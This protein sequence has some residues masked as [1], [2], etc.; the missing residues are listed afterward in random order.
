VATTKPK[1][2][3]LSVIRSTSNFWG[4]FVSKLN[5]KLGKIEEKA[6]AVFGQC[7]KKLTERAN[8]PPSKQNRAKL[9]H[10]STSI[11]VFKRKW[12]CSIL[13]PVL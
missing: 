4:F 12:C 2:G 1:I 13:W 7:Y 9:N 10:S 11:S 8:L 6:L 3:A 5:S